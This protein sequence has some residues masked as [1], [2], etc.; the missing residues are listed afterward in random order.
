MDAPLYK[1]HP[2]SSGPGNGHKGLYFDRFFNRYAPD[3]SIDKES[4]KKWIDTVAGPCGD[5]NQLKSASRAQESL[6]HALDGKVEKLRTTWHFATGLGNPHPVENGFAWHPTLGVPYLTGT[7][8]KGLVRAWVEA[9]MDSEGA[10]EKAQNNNRLV[11][12]YRWFGSEDKD[13]KKRAKLRKEGFEPPSKG[14]NPDTEAGM[15]IFFDA[16]PTAPVTLACDVMTP[17]YGK[18][19][20][21]GGEIKSVADEPARVP[22]DWHNP[23]PIP[24]LVVKNGNFMF[25]IAP[26]K[27]PHTE[28]ERTAIKDELDKVMQ[29]L[30]DALQYLGAGSKTATGYGRLE[31]DETAR[32]KREQAAY[33]KRLQQLSPEKRM[34]EKISQLGEDQIAKMFGRNFNK[35]LQSKGE[36]W[37][38]FIGLVREIHGEQIQSWQSSP[39]KNMRKTFNKLY[40]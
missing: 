17:H 15:F 7:A 1:E 25:C 3:W 31:V 40:G 35:T 27:Q 4:K 26:R 19:Y 38:V 24:F 33:Q 29:A 37:D 23:V 2:T 12:L 39:N 21:Q 36:N 13:P 16:I 28:A 22:A 10:D 8:V 5:R 32:N 14:D 6:C 9:W 30:T 11:I 20:E 18:W 34:R